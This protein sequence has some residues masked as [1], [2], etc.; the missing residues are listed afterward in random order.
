MWSSGSSV[1]GGPSPFADPGPSSPEWSL[2]DNP[3]G[4]AIPQGMGG[5]RDGIDV[6]G[7]QRETHAAIYATES[8][9]PE[10]LHSA[11]P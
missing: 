2:L 6:G 5:L 8:V 7:L 3:E 9:A 10:P 1:S 4:T 11:L